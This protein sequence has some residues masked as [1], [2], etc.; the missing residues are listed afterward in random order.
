MTT[1]DSPAGLPWLSF[2]MRFVASP[3]MVAVALGL[4]GPAVLLED[5]EPET[6]LGGPLPDH[7]RQ[8]DDTSADDPPEAP[9]A[10]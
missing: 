6:V 10:R 1:C 3:V 8:A 2:G 7:A 4:L 9:A 5:D